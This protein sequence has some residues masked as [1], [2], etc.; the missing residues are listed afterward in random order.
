MACCGDFR[1]GF[2]YCHITISEPSTGW[3]AER[4]EPLSLSTFMHPAAAIE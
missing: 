3:F 2:F 4:G 1:N